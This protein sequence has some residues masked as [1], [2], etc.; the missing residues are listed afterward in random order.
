VLTIHLATLTT[1]VA[2][3]LMYRVSDWTSALLIVGLILCVLSIIAI[4]EAAVLHRPS[5]KD[6][7]AANPNEEL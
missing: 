5:A 2:G 7:A 6:S 3:I 4:L 1:G